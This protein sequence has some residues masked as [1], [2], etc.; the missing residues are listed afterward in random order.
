MRM[1]TLAG[2]AVAA[3]LAVEVGQG[4]GQQGEAKAKPESAAAATVLVT[5]DLACNWRLDGKAH[6]SIAA[7]DS[8][9]ASLSLGQH[10]LVATTLDGRDKIEKEA[11]IDEAR[12]VLV[13]FALGP[14]R[15]AR[16]QPQQIPGEEAARSLFQACAKLPDLPPKVPA[17]PA[18]APCAKAIYT[19][20]TS[21]PVKISDTPPALAAS[22]REYLS[23]DPV[24]FSLAYI[25]TKIG[26]GE[27]AGP[28]K[29]YSVLYTGYLQDGTVFDSSAK[30]PET[31]PFVLQQGAH[32]V[33][34]GWDTGF[35]GMRVGGKR[36]LFIPHQLAYG[37]KG[38]GA[39]PPNA[40]LIFDIELVSQTD[41]KPSLTPTAAAE[42]TV[43]DET[44]KIR[45][46]P[47][48]QMPPAQRSATSGTVW[49]TTTMT[50]QNST[51]YE[52][53]VFYDGPVSK[54]L[55]LAPGA[56]QVENLAP[57]AFHVAGRVS[58][59]DVLPFY[60]EESYD[61]SANYSETFYIRQ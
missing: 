9:T 6:G 12:Q 50:V 7:G 18:G 46:G 44:E 42:P 25:D 16:L 15:D 49:G 39:V 31:G 38:N 61:G 13:R 52:L 19:L 28:H 22:V 4:I 20:T 8:T 35:Y 41:S 58:A 11:D 3:A 54:K 17:L 47:H 48:A 2:F 55:I 14:V 33:I 45:I 26:T 57:G 37:P 53:T 21:P 51:P 1:K 60:G 59:P 23:I 36:R 29:W 30:H 32:G 24:S 43:H 27:L 56:S 10:L 40:D 5:C 34:P